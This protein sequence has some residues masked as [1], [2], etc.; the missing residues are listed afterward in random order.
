MGLVDIC[1]PNHLH[2]V[3]AIEAAKASKHRLRKATDWVLR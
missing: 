1:V 2:R 3:M